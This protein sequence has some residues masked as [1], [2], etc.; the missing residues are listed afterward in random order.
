MRCPK[1][2][3]NNPDDANFCVGCGN[4]FG[5]R[6]MQCSTENPSDASF[7]KHCGI[8]L[9]AKAETSAVTASSE[10]ISVSAEHADSAVLEGERRTVTA[11]F[12]D[13]KGSTE[14]I[15]DVDPEE[16]RSLVDPV[17]R[18]MI[19]AVHRFG[20]YVAQ[21]TGD[22]IFAIFGAPVAHEDH[23][24]RALHAALAMQEDLRRHGDRLRNEGR[25]PVEARIGVNTGEVVLRTIEIG[26]HTEY[27]AVGHVTHLAARM[28]TLAA[29]GSIAATEATQRL[30]QGYFEFH[31]LGPT[32]IKGLSVPIEV[33]EVVRAGP[34]RTHFQLAVRRGLTGFVGRE[35]ELGVLLERFED[36]SAGRG[37]IVFISGEAGIGKSRLLYEF[38]RVLTSAGHRITWLEGQCVSYG[39]SVPFLPVIDQLRKNFRIEEF[40]GETEIIAKVE[41]G[42]RALGGIE[43]HVPFIRY[44]LSVDPGD[45]TVASMDARGRLRAVFAALRALSQR[46]AALRPLV[47]VV[48]DLNWIDGSSEEYLAW[49]MD[50]MATMPVMLI[51]T[52]RF[53]YTPPFRVHSFQSTLSLTTLAQREALAVAQGVLGVTEL[54]PEVMDALTEKAEGVPLFIEEVAKTLLDLGVLRREN[55]AVCLVRDADAVSV[56]NTIQDII[57]ARLDRLSEEGKRTVQ[58]ASVIGHEFLVRLLSRVYDISDRLEQLLA[59]LQSVEL[60]LEKAM[61]Q[62]PTYIFKHAVI[63]DVAYSSLLR[64]RR[65]HLHRAVGYG[66]EELYPE[67]LTEHYEELA[68]HFS[69]G[70]EWAKAFEYLAHS[71]DRAKD[72]GAAQLAVGWYTRALEAAGHVQGVVAQKRLAE[73]YQRRGQLL[74]AT[75]H[76]DE[77]VAD[78]ERVLGI[79]R[80]LNDRGLEA[81]TLADIAYAHLVRYS[82]DHIPALVR[83]AE[84]AYAI[85]REIGDDRPLARTQVLMG[86]VDLMEARLPEAQARFADALRLARAGGFRQIV[87]QAQAQLSLQRQWQTD[88]N[89]VI[90]ICREGEATARAI[91]DGF[92][93]VFLMSN[94]VFAHIGRGEYREAY[95]L[96]GAARDLAR[97]RDNHFIVGRVT[98]TLGFIHQEFGDFA[99][100]RELDR[101]SASL[102]RYIKNGNVE[103]SALINLGFDDLHTGAPLRALSH[104]EETLGR[105]EKAFG[106]HRWR[107]G[108]HLRFGLA[109]ALLA[110]DRD[111]EALAQAEQGLA[112]AEATGSRKY[113][114]WFHLIRG[115]IALRAGQT[116]PAAASLQQALDIARA[117]GYPTLTWEAAHRLAQAQAASHN[118][119]AAVASATL[120]RE[121]IEGTAAGAP[122][123][124][125]GASFAAWPRVV[126]VY[127]TLEGLRRA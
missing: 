30:C 64:E 47:L 112:Q 88:F 85:A 40:D 19:D 65:K 117:V 80:E 89:A 63:Q 49:F 12:A 10:R 23:P 123:P 11:L 6:C 103:I 50:S 108:I 27:T 111:S 54:P 74:V 92:N 15:R 100:A 124:E 86:S 87:V 116:A 7:C 5:I 41:H 102:G 46:A 4:A 118:T 77:A 25:A 98:N 39:Q 62:D 66:L 99:R 60:I 94:R 56:P 42:M 31:A 58:V 22:G 43:S 45:T 8:R 55:G 24:Q 121:T 109:S 70:E 96:A 3:R 72:A 120:A 67:R 33:Y 97:E 75:A 34:L 57:M 13:I 101:E 127:E 78:A 2:A 110:L 81:E 21:S 115:E 76:H 69:Q 36:V 104:F 114:G 18:L 61:A 106:A 44:L 52:H 95:E 125:L 105:A 1:C 59:E 14:L 17:L 126:E 122:E 107:W 51:L 84:Q 79:A 29:A 9:G 32:A 73:V 68:Y 113:V 71:G 37:Q 82:S 48:E 20:G 91:R 93:E 119:A 26:G 90:A 83:Y 53:A 16:A 28:Q 35:R 38:R